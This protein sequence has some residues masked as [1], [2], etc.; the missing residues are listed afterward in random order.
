MNKRLIIPCVAAACLVSGCSL[1]EVRSKSKFGPEFRHSGT[2]NTDKARWSAQQGV[3]LKWEKGITTGLT[4]RR[5]D[6]NDGGG[7]NDNGVWFDFSFPLWKA[8]KKPD[9]QTK[10]IEM[11]EKR[12]AALQAEIQTG[13]KQ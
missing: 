9:T 5:R 6:D 1:Q 2:K 10:R 13:G 8:K 7:N 12:L 3:E 11:L 4:Y